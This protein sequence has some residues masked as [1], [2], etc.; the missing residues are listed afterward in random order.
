MLT[1]YKELGEM[2]NTMANIIAFG[3]KKLTVDRNYWGNRFSL[4]DMHYTLRFI[5]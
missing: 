1:I 3:F 5:I 2:I 4:C